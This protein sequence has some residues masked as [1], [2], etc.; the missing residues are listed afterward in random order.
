MGI[1]FA[2]PKC[3]EIIKAHQRKTEAVEKDGY[4]ALHWAALRGNESTCKKLLRTEGADVLAQD[5]YG[6]SAIMVAAVNGYDK[7]VN[8]LLKSRADAKAT[9]RWGKTALD[10][11]TEKC[12]D[13]IKAHQ[14]ELKN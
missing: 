9:N 2:T 5:K 3:A 12:A 4:S 6:N 1:H 11:A 14:A 8:I 10:Y 7:V 13:V